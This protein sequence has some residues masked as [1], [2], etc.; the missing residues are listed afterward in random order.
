MKKSVYLDTTI[1]SYLF[2]ERDSI[3]TY[4]DI[5][6]RWWNEERQRFDLWISEETIAELST[7]NY[8]NKTQILECV[9]EIS[10]L[11][12]DISLVAIADIYLKNYLMPQTLKG[13][14]FHLANANKK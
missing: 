9:S 10:V 12:P 4:V 5:T 13:D 3:G 6:R 2:D 7:G 14:A 11:P 1:P 8:P